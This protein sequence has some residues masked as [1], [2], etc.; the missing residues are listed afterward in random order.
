MATEFKDRLKSARKY[1]GMTQVE[2]AQAVGT[3]QGS[4]SD[5]EVGRNK[6]STNTV[7]IAL[8]LGVNAHWLA[9]GE[10]SMTSDTKP[11]ANKSHILNDLKEK[12]S[13]LNTDGVLT[14]EQVH[15]IFDIVAVAMPAN[16]VPLISWVAAGSWSEVSPV[17][18]D[19]ALGYYPRPRNLSD[20]GF[21]LKVR[22][23]SMWPE[24]KPD[25]IIY[26]EPNIST[27]ALK[28]GDLIVVQ[29]NDDTEATFKQLV[30]GE[31]ESDMYLKPLNPDWPEQ[32]ML[33]MGEC[34]LVGKV[35]G[36][37]VEY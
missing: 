29:C 36:K 16:D 1:A 15:N 24:F 11:K 27:L 8:A 30:L 23:R 14:D 26:V 22:G 28:D 3:S 9:T 18:L 4:I 10:G 25:D 21:A 7:K 33:P 34:R 37:L 13:A 32:K 20:Q 2:L 6:I 12:I 17:T 35:V 19:D 31:T 5:L